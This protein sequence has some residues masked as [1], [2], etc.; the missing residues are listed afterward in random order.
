MLLQQKVEVQV[1]IQ[2]GAELIL[3]QTER[4]GKQSVGRRQ[5]VAAD[6]VPFET[7]ASS[8]YAIVINRSAHAL[9]KTTMKFNVNAGDHYRY[10]IVP[11]PKPCE[12]YVFSRITC[13][14]QFSQRCRKLDSRE[15]D[16][17]VRH[18]PLFGEVVNVM[19]IIGTFVEQERISAKDTLEFEHADAAELIPL[20]GESIERTK[21][22]LRRD[23]LLRQIIIGDQQ[24]QESLVI[25]VIEKYI[26]IGVTLRRPFARSGKATHDRPDLARKLR[27]SAGPSGGT[28]A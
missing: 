22:L 25:G 26:N 3:G 17:D 13:N 11:G 24:R 18:R 14:F 27:H 19:P 20:A 15:I 4:V 12:I 2:F 9:R 10:L 28:A 5:A 7:F 16:I 8:P 23:H 1:S 21:A 6:A